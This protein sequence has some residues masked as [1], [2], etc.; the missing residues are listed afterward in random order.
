LVVHNGSDAFITTYNSN[1]TGS[2]ELISLTADISGSNVRLRASAN[3]PNTAVKMYRVLLGDSE[4]DASS[5]NTKTVGQ[6]T[7]SSSATTMDTFSTDSANGAHYV[8]VGNSSSESAASIS[9]VFVVSDGSDAYVSSGPIVSTK[10]S[11]QLTFTASLTGSTVTVSSASTS[12]ASTTVNAYRVN[13]L[14]ASAGAST[15]EQVLVSTTQTISG[16]KTFSN[17]VVKM[18][19]L[20]TSDPAVAGQLWNSSGTLKISAG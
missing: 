13:L 16:A 2:N 4:S 12:G 17:A 20:P 18:T 9:E 19:N 15:S 3:E 14:R 8:V 6:T 10:G 5:T 11:D 7:T 1:F